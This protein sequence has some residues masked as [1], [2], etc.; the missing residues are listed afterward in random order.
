MAWKFHSYTASCAGGGFVTCCLWPAS[1]LVQGGIECLWCLKEWG[2]FSS[3]LYQPGSKPAFSGKVEEV[4][5]SLIA[6]V[7]DLSAPRYIFHLTVPFLR[8]SV[9]LV[10]HRQDSWITETHALMCTRWLS[11]RTATCLLLMILQSTPTSLGSMDSMVSGRVPSVRQA[12]PEG[13][14][15]LHKA[16]FTA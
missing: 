3:S 8:C 10:A 7:I 13:T 14:G 11:C 12:L 1:R 16:S 15:I 6:P 4:V 2:W 5:P 9:R